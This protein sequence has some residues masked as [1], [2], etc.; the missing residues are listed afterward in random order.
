MVAL[1]QLAKTS[2]MSLTIIVVLCLLSFV[3]QTNGICG[4]YDLPTGCTC[5]ND[6]LGNL[7]KVTC[8]NAQLTS[9]PPGLPPA[10]HMRIE[11]NSIDIISDVPYSNRIKYLFLPQNKIRLVQDGAFRN[12]TNLNIL[13]LKSNKIT[14]LRK[15]TFE[16]LINLK[17]L[18]LMDNPI[19]VLRADTLDGMI[20][21]QLEDLNMDGCQLYE[22]EDG[23]LD[24]LGQLM[25]LTLSHN[26]LHVMP[27]LGCP[28]HSIENLVT[29]DVS[30]N[31][32]T[33]VEPSNC[34]LPRLLH[35]NLNNNRIQT[36]NASFYG[37]SIEYLHSLRLSHNNLSK[38]DFHAFSGSQNLTTLDLSHNNLVELDSATI[39]WKQVSSVMVSYNPWNC[40]CKNT[41]LITKEEVSTLNDKKTVR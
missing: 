23:A 22:F 16:G 24:S 6:T 9:F 14:S 1:V 37:P 28:G 11:N 18:V 19:Y 27:V 21:P 34:Y 32:I 17:T 20:L 2:K 12:L 35:L 41:W 33:H 5:V 7:M 39:P 38:I 40:D 30:H 25:F 13:S 3:C 36:L 26:N 8:D 29:F 31:R 15:A 4:G 10:S